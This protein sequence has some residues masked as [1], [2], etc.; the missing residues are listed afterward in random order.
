MRPLVL[1]L[2]ILMIVSLV[3]AGIC[4]YNFQKLK[5]EKKPYKKMQITYWCF[6]VCVIVFGILYKYFV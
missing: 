3:I 1:I 6:F 2:F 4:L 5:K